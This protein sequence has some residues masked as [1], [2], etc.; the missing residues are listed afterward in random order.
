[1]T[2]DIQGLFTGI[3]IV[4]GEEMTLG[5]NMRLSETSRLHWNTEKTLDAGHSATHGMDGR[6][7]IDFKAGAIPVELNPMEIRTFELTVVYQ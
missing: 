2:V 1:M 6:E 5:G 4:G 3:T 7:P